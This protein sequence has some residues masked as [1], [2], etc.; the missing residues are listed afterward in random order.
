MEPIIRPTPRAIFE[1]FTAFDR[2]REEGVEREIGP[3]S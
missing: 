3:G 1:A 2:H